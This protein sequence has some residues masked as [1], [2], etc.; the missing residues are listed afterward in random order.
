MFW[1]L[2]TRAWGTSRGLLAPGHE[3][4]SIFCRWAKGIVEYK[5]WDKN[6]AADKLMKHLGLYARD[7]AQTS[8]PIRALLDAVA[9]RG[10]KAK[11][12]GM[13]DSIGPVL[14]NSLAIRSD[15]LRKLAG[16]NWSQLC[17]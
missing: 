11:P 3:S 15:Q 17:P 4:V 5:L 2:A 7:N 16:A 13:T 10:L 12:A 1:R 6:R 14:R 9:A 8:D